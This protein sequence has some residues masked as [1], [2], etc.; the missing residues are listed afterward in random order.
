MTSKKEN[1][2]QEHLEREVKKQ[3]EIIKR[4]GFRNH[5]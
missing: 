3:L 1:N 4:G 5:K 2:I